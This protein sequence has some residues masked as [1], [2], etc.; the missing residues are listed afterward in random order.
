MKGVIVILHYWLPDLIFILSAGLS[1]GINLQN[2]ITLLC[3]TIQLD[4]TNLNLKKLQKSQ[5]RGLFK[6]FKS[7][8]L[9]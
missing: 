9:F 5:K 6:S 1:Y 8:P 4:I 7:N 3:S 2:S